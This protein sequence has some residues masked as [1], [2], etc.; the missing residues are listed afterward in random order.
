MAPV[1]VLRKA[2]ALIEERGWHRGSWHG[3]GGSVCLGR[4]LEIATGVEPPYPF[5]L[6]DVDGYDEMVAATGCGRGQ[7]TRWNDHP[8]RSRGDVLAAFDKAIALA[9]A[10]S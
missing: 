9:E 1:D 4:A 10:Q 3:P 5:G 2:K 6:E 7:L 8:A